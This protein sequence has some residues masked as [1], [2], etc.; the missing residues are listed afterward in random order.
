MGPNMDALNRAEEV[1][2][3]RVARNDAAFREANE[4][5]RATADGWRMTGRLPVICECAD[6]GCS[7]LLQLTG[8]EYEEVRADPRWFINAPGHQVN[9]QGWAVVVGER[10]HYLIVEKIGEAGEIVEELDPRTGEEDG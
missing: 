10:G 3:E 7:E 1:T 2:A 4:S 5:I 6:V 9:A 8:P